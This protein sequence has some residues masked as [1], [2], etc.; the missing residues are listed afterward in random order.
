MI[1]QHTYF[2]H[3]IVPIHI[4]MKLCMYI[5]YRY[6]QSEN[7]IIS[8]HV[9]GHS[10]PTLTSHHTALS[11]RPV[12]RAG[13]CYSKKEV[14]HQQIFICKVQGVVSGPQTTSRM[15]TLTRHMP[16]D[17]CHSQEEQ[18]LLE[19]CWAEGFSWQDEQCGYRE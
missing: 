17:F 6:T 9:I 10:Y 8:L 2:I 1:P 13:I 19:A 12:D 14:Q 5:V 11:G 7:S 16:T 18:S 4:Y 3:S 15:H